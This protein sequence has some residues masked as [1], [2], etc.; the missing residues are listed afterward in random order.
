MQKYLPGFEKVA[1]IATGPQI[2]VRETRRIVGRYTLTHEDVLNARSF[3]DQIAEG[4]YEI[5]VHIPNSEGATFE[6]VPKGRSYGI[7]YRCLVP[8]EIRNLLVSGRAISATH[9]AAGSL[10]VM[11]ICMTTGE[12]AG[13]AATL[14]CRY[15]S[16][17]HNVPVSEIQQLINQSKIVSKD[18]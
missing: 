5:D 18:A 8:Q 14:A 1:L 6:A 17:A 7:P 11:P 2:G 4:A 12:A 16:D 9:L 3:D 10:R 13:Y 15:G